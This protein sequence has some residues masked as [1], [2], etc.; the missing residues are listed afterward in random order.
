LRE[1]AVQGASF[2][3]INPKKKAK[4]KSYQNS[5]LLRVVKGQLLQSYSFLDYLRTGF[6]INLM[7]AID[8]T[9]YDNVCAFCWRVVVLTVL[10]VDRM[11]I[12][13]FRRR[14]TTSR[15]MP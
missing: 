13:A 11:A 9:A 12:Q 2:P 8:F 6:Q 5:G 7:T 14:C 10:D 3:L 1:L 15:L 4:K